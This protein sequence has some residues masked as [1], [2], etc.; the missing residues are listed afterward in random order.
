MHSHTVERA[1][2]SKVLRFALWATFV[3]IVVTAVA[4]VRGHSLALISEAGHNVSDFLALL[5]A[6]AAV[7]LETRPPNPSKT[8][9]YHRAGVLVAFVNSV[10]LVGLAFY[11]FYE[12]A[13]RIREPQ[14]VRA[15]LM[16]V[17]AAAGVVMNG[18]IAALL[19]RAG[20][21]VN[22]RSAFLHMLGATVSTAAV[23][24]GGWA[25]L[26]TGAK[27]CDAARSCAIGA[28]IPG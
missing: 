4:G 2:T 17:V 7:Y 9:G 3:Y 13:Q 18:V 23:I 26:L 11:I 5:L 27:W 6:L 25:I 15:G 19:H 24:V 1:D 21:N 12:A 28:L 20:R 16:M 22:L 14:P 8:Y 10:T